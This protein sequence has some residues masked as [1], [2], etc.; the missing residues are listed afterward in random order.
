V[1]IETG[2]I[3]N[4]EEEDYLNSEVGQDE[5][6]ASITRALGS[7]IEWVDKQQAP[8]SGATIPVNP[9]G[10]TPIGFLEAVEQKERAASAR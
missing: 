2:F 10:K 1:L 3:T 5:I 7:Y 4:K 6:S 9:R 8:S